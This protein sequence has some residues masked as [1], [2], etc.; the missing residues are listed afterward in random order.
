MYRFLLNLSLASHCSRVIELKRYNPLCLIPYSKIKPIFPPLFRKL[1]LK[2]IFK[3][4]TIK[5]NTKMADGKT[6]R[7]FDSFM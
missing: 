1:K 4:N 6:V 7:S 2:T 3:A 5:E